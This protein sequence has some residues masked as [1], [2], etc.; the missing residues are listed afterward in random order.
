MSKK[1]CGTLKISRMEILD[2]NRLSGDSRDQ[3]YQKVDVN[4]TFDE[5]IILALK[6]H[7]TD[8]ESLSVFYVLYFQYN[9]YK[10]NFY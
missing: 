6:G 4:F 2:I 7:E 5:D 8:L 10:W 1:L 9:R 3:V